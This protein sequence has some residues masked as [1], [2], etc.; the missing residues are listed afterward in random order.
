MRE[1]VASDRGAGYHENSRDEEESMRETKERIVEAVRKASEDNR[2]S[3]ERAHE[4][5]KELKVPLGEIGSVCND[6]KIK[7][8]ACQLGCF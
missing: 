2:L 5:A 1:M 3:C 7:I 6:L 8:T 4:L